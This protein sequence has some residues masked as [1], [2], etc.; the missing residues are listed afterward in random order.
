MNDEMN[1][2]PQSNYDE[3]QQMQADHDRQRAQRSAMNMWENCGVGNLHAKAMLPDLME[4]DKWA[5]AWNAAQ[6]VIDRKGMLVLLGDRGNGKTQLA[7]ELVRRECKNLNRCL[8]IRTRQVGMAIRESYGS[9]AR[10]SE[11]DVVKQ[12]TKPYLLVLDEVQEKP[13]TEFEA[14]TMNLILD[15]R[16]ESQRPTVMIANASVAAFKKIV[17]AS[18]TDR[19]HDRGSTI[20]FDWPSFRGKGA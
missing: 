13:D 18:I 15:M 6:Q 19:I 16:Y 17:G 2:Y 8:Y 9:A 14:R 3:R 20:V 7:I 5:K 1:P 12:F 4:H 10:T 11:M